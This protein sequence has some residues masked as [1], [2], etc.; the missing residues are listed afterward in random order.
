M[1]LAHLTSVTIFVIVC[2]IAEWPLNPIY[3]INISYRVT[4]M[5]IYG[6]F[7]RNWYTQWV[8]SPVTI[9]SA[10]RVC[11]IDHCI[12]DLQ[13]NNI[14]SSETI[15][16]IDLSRN[17]VQIVLQ[18]IPIVFRYTIWQHGYNIMSLA[19]NTFNNIYISLIQIHLDSLGRM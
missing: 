13:I 14:A 9:L 16:E 6:L 18:W 12:D 3:S 1:P 11:L 2:N 8:L 19:F 5:K 15:S 4:R 10:R 7:N 17:D